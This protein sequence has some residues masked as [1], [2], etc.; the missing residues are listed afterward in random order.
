MNK[1]KFCLKCGNSIGLDEKFCGGCGASVAEMENEMNS[2]AVTANSGVPQQSVPQNNPQMNQN[3][4]QQNNPQMNQNQFQQNNMPYQNNP[5]QGG[6]VPNMGAQAVKAPNPLIEKIKAKPAIV[7]VPAAILV[8][9]IV[10]IIIL[11]NILKY[12][13]INAEDIL[14]VKF[15]GV[16]GYG[17]AS[18][19]LDYDKIDKLE[20]KKAKD[21]VE[22]STMR[23]ALYSTTA[24]GDSRITADV[25]KK[26]NLKNGDKVK[27][28]VTYNKDYLKKNKIKLKNTEFDVEVTELSEGEKIDFFK[29]VKVTFEGNDGNGYASVDT[30]DAYDF[31]YFK[32][33]SYADD[34][35]NGDTYTVTATCSA[36]LN[37]AGKDYWFKHDGKY[38]VCSGEKATKDYK[39]SG[40]KEA[41]EVDAF[42]NIELETSSGS[43][44]LVVTGVNTDKCSDIVKEYISYSVDDSKFYKEGDKVKV[45]AKPNYDFKDDGYK[46]KEETKEITISSD[47]AKYVTADNASAAIS[48]LNDKISYA[49]DEYKTNNV[50]THYIAD[51]VPIDGDVKSFESV[52]L[53]NSY[54]SFTKEK[55]KEV[56][57]GLFGGVNVGNIN[58]IQQIYKADIKTKESKT[59]TVYL[60]LTI[61]NVIQNKSEFTYSG[62]ISVKAYE[63][64]SEA[65]AEINKDS[66]MTHDDVNKKT[67]TKKDDSS[68]KASTTTTTKKAESEKSTTKA[69]TKTTAKKSSETTTMV[70]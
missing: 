2:A 4:F 61:E 35:S 11:C 17:T 68:S 55:E 39:V 36:D 45:T 22:E 53:E 21:V 33:D 1:I 25:D 15:E 48:A 38:Y 50:D 5:V 20:L 27:V 40:L 18:V 42:E 26:E 37:K 24:N 16:D 30:S 64:R 60:I 7:A 31:I 32:Y 19:S 70:P 51:L 9:L 28:T 44:F 13:V 57:T 43:P 29:G 54:L 65:D 52:T 12:Q 47:C 41:T 63:S 67:E 6:Y 66:T 34:L 10:G 58:K 59:K 46:L 62:D 69:T 14:D 8:V 56:S 23:I 49:V 3:Q